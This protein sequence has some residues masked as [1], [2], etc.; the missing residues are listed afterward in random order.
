MIM[1][2]RLMNIGDRLRAKRARAA[3]S[4]RGTQGHRRT[5]FEEAIDQTGAPVAEIGRQWP[6][7]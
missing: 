3:R 7:P 1:R 6:R 4:L 5:Q 2:R